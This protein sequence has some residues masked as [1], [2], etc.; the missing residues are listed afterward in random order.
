MIN[1]LPYT[2][3]GNIEIRISDFTIQLAFFEQARIIYGSQNARYGFS[4]SVKDN[5]E[6]PGNGSSLHMCCSS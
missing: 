6:Q 1:Y 4:I 3:F 2:N 5:F